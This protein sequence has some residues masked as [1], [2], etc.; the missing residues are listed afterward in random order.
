MQ[1]VTMR[2]DY[3]PFRMS[4]IHEEDKQNDDCYD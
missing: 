3:P 1:K 2:I 4:E